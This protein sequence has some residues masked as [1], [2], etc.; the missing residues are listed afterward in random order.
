MPADISAIGYFA[1]IAAFL[2]IFIVIYAV[3]LKT[4]ILGDNKWVSLFTS[5]LVAS[6]FISIGGARQY[7]Q[8]IIPW[9]AI[10]ILSLVFL[11]MITGI[12][13]K[14]AESFNKGISLAF[15][16]LFVIV[17]LIAGFLIFSNL[18]VG[19]LPGPNFGYNANPDALPALDWL[20]SPRVG[21]AVLLIII[22]IAVSWILV[23]A[24]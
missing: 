17:F 9:F 20:Y 7:V 16:I 24:K 13:G 4:K 8:T 14:P 19:Y 15:I 2:I 22:S 3:L 10:L 12:V 21:G 11:L 5:L 23:K 6:I 18:I 1:P